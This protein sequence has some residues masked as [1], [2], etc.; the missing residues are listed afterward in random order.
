MVYESP[1][2]I[3]VKRK[4]NIDKSFIKANPNKAKIFIVATVINVPFNFSNSSNLYA[5]FEQMA[6]IKLLKAH[7]IAISVFE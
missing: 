6:S 3:E 4:K 5:Y 7:I 1:P 2:V